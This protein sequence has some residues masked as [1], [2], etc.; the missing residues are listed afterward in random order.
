LYVATGNQKHYQP[1]PS[2]PRGRIPKSATLV[3]R[4]KRKLMTKPGRAIYARRKT[5]VDP[6]FGRMLASH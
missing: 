5:I 4:M 2:S 6:V 1:T 3:E